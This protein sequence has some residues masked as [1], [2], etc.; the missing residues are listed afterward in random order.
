VPYAY[1]FNA[2][3]VPWMEAPFVA[4]GFVLLFKYRRRFE[5][6]VILAWII[7]GI[8]P[9][10]LSEHAYPKRLSTV[11]PALDIIAAI[12]LATLLSSLAPIRRRLAHSFAALMIVAT[13]LGYTA[14]L[15]NVWFGGRF[16]KYGEPQEIQMA[17]KFS[18]SITPGTIV[19]ADLNR[20]YGGGK[21]LYLMLD[22]LNTPS[23]RP[24]V[25][26]L[27]T[28][29]AMKSL[30]AEPL[31]APKYALETLPYIWTKMREQRQEIATYNEWRKVV[32]VVQLENNAAPETSEWYSSIMARCESPKTSTIE[33][34]GTAYIALFLVECDLSQLKSSESVPDAR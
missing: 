29:P 1:G 21:Y 26:A 19:V 20:S 16:W 27:A 18:E 11:F 12:S 34:S 24:N 3:T 13:L 5:V 9:G 2:R 15:S 25:L 33:A 10:I 30:I 4:L 32:F 31:M 17:R 23:N 6:A 7:A 22:Y 8:M 14:F 28:H